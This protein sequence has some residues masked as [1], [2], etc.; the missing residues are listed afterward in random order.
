[1]H[2]LP[3][4]CKHVWYWF[5]DLSSSRVSGGFGINPLQYS[6]IK[7]YFDLIKVEPFDWELSLIKR[8]DMELVKFYAKKAEETNKKS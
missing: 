6:D 8:F 7:A 2:D 3:D 4:S 5:N 1:M